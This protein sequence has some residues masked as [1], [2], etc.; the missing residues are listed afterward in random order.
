LVELVRPGDGQ[1][2]SS[3]SLEAGFARIGNCKR[4]SLAGRSENIFPFGDQKIKIAHNLHFDENIIQFRPKQPIAPQKSCPMQQ[5][6]IS[7]YL[8]LGS[9]QLQAAMVQS[10]AFRLIR[11]I[12][13]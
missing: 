5:Y 3:P 4:L 11:P 13:S 1:F 6:L 7:L 9:S 10:T 8:R 2:Q 12:G